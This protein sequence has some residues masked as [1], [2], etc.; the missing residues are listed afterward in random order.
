MVEES[1]QRE[2]HLADAYV[3]TVQERADTAVKDAEAAKAAWTCRVCLSGEVDTTVVPCGHVLC[4]RCAAAVTRC[5]FCRN[6][7]VK[8]LRL[9]RP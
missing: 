1:G 9:Y 6:A 5:P 7:V 4:N 2:A 3:A 8:A